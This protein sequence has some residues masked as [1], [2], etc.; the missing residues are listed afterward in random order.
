M[1]ALCLI[2]K[3]QTPKPAPL[4]PLELTNS[5]Y[6]CELEVKKSQL[7]DIILRCKYRPVR[8]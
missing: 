8:D 4:L 2:K 3:F 7:C 5:Q 6:I 1:R